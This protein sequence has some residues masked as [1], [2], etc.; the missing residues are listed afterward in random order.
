MDPARASP[1]DRC[2]IQKPPLPETR[3]AYVTDIDG[4]EPNCAPT[5]RH[6]PSRRSLEPGQGSGLAGDQGN[7]A[8]ARLARFVKSHRILCRK[9][10]SA[11]KVGQDSK[12]TMA[13]F[14]CSVFYGYIRPPPARQV[15]LA[16]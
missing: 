10:A 3:A 12:A 15:A 5:A 4:C 13:L 6:H 16:G 8:F 11:G 7:S 2:A 9:L 14:L 1:N